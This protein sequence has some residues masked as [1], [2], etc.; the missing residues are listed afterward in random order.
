MRNSCIIG[1]WARFHDINR[2]LVDVFLSATNC[3]HRN[4]VVFPQDLDNGSIINRKEFASAVLVDMPDMIIVEINLTSNVAILGISGKNHPFPI[5]RKFGVPVALSI[6]D[7]GVSRIDL[8]HE[9]IR[10]VETYDLSYADL[11]QPV[12]NSLQYSFLPGAG[13][14]DELNDAVTGPVA[15]CRSDAPGADKPSR[16]CA[17]RFHA[18]EASH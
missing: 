3:E 9:Y 10:A 18:F 12:R 5:Y 1:I 11:K 6:D 15:D 14:W 2:Q 4:E 8:T 17:A 13:L 7:E 16:S